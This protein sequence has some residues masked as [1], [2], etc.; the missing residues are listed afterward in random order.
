MNESCTHMIR[1]EIKMSWK[2][3]YENFANNFVSTW[4]VHRIHWEWQ[5]VFWALTHWNAIQS[6][7]TL[8]LKSLFRSCWCETSFFLLLSYFS[9][10]WRSRTSSGRKKNICQVRVAS[11]I[12]HHR[13]PIVESKKEIISSNN[14]KNNFSTCLSLSRSCRVNMF[15]LF[16]RK[17]KEAKFV[18][19]DRPHAGIGSKFEQHTHTYIPLQRFDLQLY[20]IFVCIFIW[21]VCSGARNSHFG[22]GAGIWHENWIKIQMSIS[23]GDGCRS[24]NRKILLPSPPFANATL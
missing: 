1:R 17:K 5:S 11:C 15:A 3:K 10:T 24:F 9:R 22:C 20:I 14:C 4:W 18:S 12:A 6:E 23:S 16:Q 21:L 19:V 2:Q 7:N 8:H 13:M